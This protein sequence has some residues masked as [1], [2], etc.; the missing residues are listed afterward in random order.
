MPFGA[1]REGIARRRR[2]TDDV[3]DHA[4]LASR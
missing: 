4:F 2:L 1:A 3:L